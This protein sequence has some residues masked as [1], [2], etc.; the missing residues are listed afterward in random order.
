MQREERVGRVSARPQLQLCEPL[1]QVFRL[2]GVSAVALPQVLQSQVLSVRPW[3]VTL[4]TVCSATVC[5][6][7][8]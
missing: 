2:L 8:L 7:K 4:A 5:L 6:Q 1:C 3:A